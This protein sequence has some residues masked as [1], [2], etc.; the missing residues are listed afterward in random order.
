MECYWK[1]RALLRLM[2]LVGSRRKSLLLSLL[3]PGAVAL[4]GTRSG[5]VAALVAPAGSSRGVVALIPLAAGSRTGVVAA[6]VALAGSRC[7]CRE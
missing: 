5:V 4:A 2:A 6:L 7:S 1:L 3:S